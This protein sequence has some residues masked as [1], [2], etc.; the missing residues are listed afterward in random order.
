MAAKIARRY[1]HSAG[2]TS[3][4]SDLATKP[5]R[6]PN[7]PSISHHAACVTK[8]AKLN[9]FNES[10]DGSQHRCAAPCTALYDDD[11]VSEDG[12]RRRRSCSLSS[13]SKA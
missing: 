2:I 10:C 13:S 11:D 1:E 4:L 7:P 9:H 8:T 6:Q 5:S 3:I 12:S